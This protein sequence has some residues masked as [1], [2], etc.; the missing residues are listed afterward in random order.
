MKRRKSVFSRLFRPIIPYFSMDKD[1]SR[2]KPKKV[3]KK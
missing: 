1:K 3:G 2:E